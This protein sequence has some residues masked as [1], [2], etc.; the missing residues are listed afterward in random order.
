MG[1]KKDVLRRLLYIILIFFYYCS[2]GA[3]MGAGPALYTGVSNFIVPVVLYYRFCGADLPAGPTHNAVISYE[4][5]HY[6][7]LFH[8]RL[9]CQTGLNIFIIIKDKRQGVIVNKAGQLAR[10]KFHKK[11]GL[12]IPSS[13]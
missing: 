13:K 7:L 11:S 3:H 9:R 5:S 2:I 6:C 4:V 1:V 12:F 10:I 8:L